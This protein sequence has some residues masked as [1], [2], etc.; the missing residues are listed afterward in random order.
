[1]KIPQL[2]E[3]LRLY[4]D[5]FVSFTAGYQL[6]KELFE[7]PDHFAIKCANELDY[8][9]TCQEMATEV[10]SDGLWEFALD[11]RLLGS[12]KLAGTVALCGKGFT[13]VEI[14]QPRLGKET[15][16][17]FVEHTEFYFSDFFAAEHILKQR[18][19]DYSH[20]EN[21]GHAWLN[22]VI[23]DKGREIKLN[24]K[25]LADVVLWEREQGL[26]Q[27]VKTENEV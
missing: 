8:L 5:A 25:P 3:E 26:L 21:P 4:S 13:W 7:R 9:E 15:D 11:N 22:I 10:G 24:D 17:G 1:M 2:G 16:A 19:I 18:G 27:P 20:Q 23:D 12:A 6:P 14:M